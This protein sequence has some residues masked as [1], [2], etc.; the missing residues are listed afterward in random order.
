M[1]ADPWLTGAALGRVGASPQRPLSP[2]ALNGS[3]CAR[4]GAVRARAAVPARWLGDPAPA[5]SCSSLQGRPNASRKVRCAPGKSQRG[6]SSPPVF[7]IFKED[8]GCPPC[9][10][11]ECHPARP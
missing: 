7:L 2:P 1:A 6:C 11:L 8:L 4:L 3:A 5:P 9:S 10:G